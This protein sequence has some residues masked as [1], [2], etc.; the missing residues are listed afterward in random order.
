LYGWAE[1]KR[2]R[3]EKEVTR[4]RGRKRAG[5]NWR[6]GDTGRG[7]Y[8]KEWQ[9]LGFGCSEE[10]KGAEIKRKERKKKKKKKKKNVSGRRRE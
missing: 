5:R 3:I 2:K 9:Q 6:M 1:K 10:K 8:G 7:V 4:K